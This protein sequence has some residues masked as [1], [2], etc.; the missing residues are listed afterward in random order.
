RDITERKALEEQLR[1]QAFHDVLTGLA[2]R[3]LFRDRLGHALTRAARGGRPTAVLYLDLDDFK[4][5]NDRLGHAAGDRLL[6]AVGERLRAATRAGDTVARLGGDEF[7]IIVEEAEP[8]D[9]AQ[10]A[11]R[12]LRTLAPP[13]S[14]DES[15]IVARA[16]VGIAVQ[17]VDS[18]DAD[19]LLR[20]AD[21]AMYAV[22]ARGGDGHVTYEPELYDATVARMELKADLRG[23]LE[24]GEL[25]V[26]YQPIVD[27]ETGGIIGS[28]A[29]MRWDHPR[30]GAIP[31]IDFIPLAEES[32]LILDLGRW[33]LESACRQT[34]AWQE[35][36]GDPDLSVSVNLSGRQVADD[37]LVADVGRILT[38]SGLDPQRLTLEITET[39]LVS[40]V[41]TTVAAFRALKALGIR[42]AIDD[43]GT[44]YSSLSYLR[45]F[46]IDIL[47]IDRSFVNSL[48]GSDDSTALVRSILDLSTTLRLDTVAEGIETSEQRSALRGLGAQRGQG[49]LF[50]RAMRPDALGDLLTREPT[51][52]KRSRPASTRTDNPR[53][54][55]T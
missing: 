51:G 55:R 49:H 3:S 20:R 26:A 9:A 12:I 27:I 8:S 1:H 22:K 50:A 7:A 29:L 47:K 53:A 41:D 30:R 13:F 44:G 43:F 31:P 42:L 46:P 2:N 15:Q 16:S 37:N 14:I 32:G 21:I 33:I 36:T 10:A 11:E 19:E 4:S 40:D 24:R 25:H 18:G 28:E 38:A 48:D 52:S 34:K 6:V 35:A 17:S 5:V 54:L 23:A 45:Q 39:V